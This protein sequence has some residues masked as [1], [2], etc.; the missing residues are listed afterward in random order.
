MSETEAALVHLRPGIYHIV[1]VGHQFH[2]QRLTDAEHVTIL[3][4][5]VVPDIKQQV[6]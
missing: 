1:V 4:P 6:M 3:P 2:D 5:G